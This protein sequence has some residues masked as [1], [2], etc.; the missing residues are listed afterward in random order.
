M[1]SSAK[2]LPLLFVAAC[3]FFIAGVICL[4]LT[5]TLQLDPATFRGYLLLSLALLIFG[6][7]E[8]INHPNQRIF[9]TPEEKLPTTPQVRRKRNVCSLGNLC[10]I[11]AILLLFAGIGSLM[12]QR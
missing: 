10:D 7:G 6:I 9:A 2:Q 5:L 1:S 3:I 8:I 4:G 12:A 11:C